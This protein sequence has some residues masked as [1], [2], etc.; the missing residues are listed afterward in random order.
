MIQSIHLKQK[1]N[2][3]PL[4]FLIGLFI[5]TALTLA[6][7]SNVFHAE[8]QFDDI[9]NIINNSHVKNL[10][11]LKS[12]W[13]YDEN[14][15]L[16]YATFAFNFEFFGPDS[17]YFHLTNICIHLLAAVLVCLLA[18]LTF[19]T[20]KL[21]EFSV[22][23]NVPLISF[24]ASLI[25]V[26][27]PIQTQAVT[28]IVQR[29]ALLATLFYVATLALYVKARLSNSAIYYVL[30]VMVAFAS[31]FTKQITATLPLTL[32]LYELLFFGLHQERTKELMLRLLPFFC[33]PAF[34]LICFY[35]SDSLESN[36][37]SMIPTTTELISRKEYLLTQFN[38]LR[39][40]VRLL[41]LPVNQN[42]DYDYPISHTFFEFKTFF[43]FLFL[44]GTF[45]FGF[46]V[47]RKYTII[48]FGVFWFF[49]TLAVESSI[50]PLDDVIFEHRLY[51]PM[52]G[53]S[54]LLSTSL[55][56]VLKK[57]S[58]YL[59]AAGCIILALSFAA[60][61]RN[62]VWK[63]RVS[64]WS[65]VIRKSPQK[66]RGYCLKADYYFEKRDFKQALELY[67]ACANLGE[68]A[69]VG[70]G[71]TYDALGDLDKAIE[72]YQKTIE[73]GYV[74]DRVLDNLATTYGKK[75]QYDLAFQFHHKALERD[76]NN[77]LTH[78]NIG[79]T[80]LNTHQFNEAI[81][82]YKKSINLNPF[83]PPTYYYLGSAYAKLG[84]SQ[85]ALEQIES[86]K[87]LNAH[88]LA[89]K[90]ARKMN[91]MTSSTNASPHTDTL[92]S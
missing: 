37:S 64:L 72:M 18:L 58:Y 24:I 50:I 23:V 42:L 63:D 54:I 73:R 92:F 75:K 85:E 53:F 11:D 84:R 34:I 35:K 56:M 76:P 74:T 4:L 77:Y 52:V 30:A 43:S 89:S 71:N 12:I 46:L 40:Y 55:W 9:E 88:E 47:R 59:I 78:L 82:S 26:S 86:L 8:F 29:A 70:L 10:K 13:E 90:L 39:T 27:H 79:V 17:F 33:V 44:L 65:D 28:Y 61:Q 81:K 83:Y 87:K 32:T 21:K 5:L 25:F 91:S 49:L 45:V 38:V 7:Y 22:S 1:K 3:G 80:Y 31:A 14:R 48:T 15:F 67:E 68:T 16:T 2:Q 6:I 60:Y 69:Y 20:P 66:A 36:L 57:R 19:Q 51:L 62:F 41:L